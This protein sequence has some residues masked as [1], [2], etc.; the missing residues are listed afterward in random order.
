[1]DRYIEDIVQSEKNGLYLLE[2]PT[3]SGKTYNSLKVMSRV[4]LK[5]MTE[6]CSDECSTSKIVYIT[7]LVKNIKDVSDDLKKQLGNLYDQNVVWIKSNADNCLTLMNVKSSD[8]TPEIRNSEEFK[9]LMRILDKLQ[10]NKSFDKNYT[11]YLLEKEFP[12]TERRFRNFIK[13]YYRRKTEHIKENRNVAIMNLI[14]KENPWLFDMYPSAL[15]SEKKIILLSV[16]KLMTKANMLNGPDIP[17]L[18]NA[19]INENTTILLDEFDASKNNITSS[20][21]RE[22]LDCVIDYIKLCRQLVKYINEEDLSI[23]LKESF[24][25]DSQY[26]F[27]TL[28]EK[29]KIFES[30]YKISSSFKSMIE[31][32]HNV[33]LFNDGLYQTVLQNNDLKNKNYLSCKYNE[34]KFLNEVFLSGDEKESI[35]LY[36]MLRSIHNYL[37]YFHK[38]VERW[39]LNYEKNEN[40]ERLN[41][42]Q[43]A[44]KITL[45]DCV[46]TILNRF[47]LDEKQK[48]FLT[49]RISTIQTKK[50]KGFC[51]DLSFYHN[52][53][54]YF[55]LKDKDYENDETNIGMKKIDKTAEKVLLYLIQRAKVVGISA[56]AEVDSVISNYDF[57]YLKIYG[58]VFKTPEDVKKRIADEMEKIWNRYEQEKI[59]IHL[60]TMPGRKN[61]EES[62]LPQKDLYEY[63]NQPFL[64]QIGKEICKYYDEKNVQYDQS[65]HIQVLKVAYDLLSTEHFQSLL[66]IGSKIPREKDIHFDATLLKRNFD[67]MAREIGV[68]AH[69]FILCKEN[70]DQDIEKAKKIL[71]KGEKV[72]LVSSYATLAEGQNI[73]YTIP[74]KADVV[75]LSEERGVTEKDLDGI[76]LD[77][78]T[79]VTANLNDE[80]DDE[81]LLKYII[82]IEELYENGELSFHQKQYAVEKGIQAA[83]SSKKRFKNDIYDCKSIKNTKTAKVIQAVG[84]INRTFNKSRN[85]YIYISN[86]LLSEINKNE[87]RR[88]LMSPELKAIY[89]VLEDKKAEDNNQESNI[90]NV[91]STKAY[92]FIQQMLKTQWTT[93]TV[94]LWKDIRM[95]AAKN[96]TISKEFYEEHKEKCFYMYIP[97]DQ[98]RYYYKSFGDFKQVTVHMEKKQ[99]GDMEVSAEAAGLDILSKNE[100]IRESFE[101]DGYPMTFEKRD[102]ILNPIFFHNI[103]LGWLGEYVGK[104]LIEDFTKIT[105]KEIDDLDVFE[106]FDYQYKDLFFDFKNWKNTYQIDKSAMRKKINKKRESV[107]GRAV[108]TVNII[109]RGDYQPEETVDGK[110]I[111][112]KS[113]VNEDGS[114]NTKSLNIVK[115]KIYDYESSQCNME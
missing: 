6:L 59:K 57:N 63:G 41:K 5:K 94:S 86:D 48:S 26:N 58:N 97:C 35:S 77:D 96:P 11:E 61:I 37:N 9:Q 83:C 49:K 56:T 3:G 46:Q 98:V 24:P 2:V 21:I 43:L 101:R 54:E 40:Q 93:N 109:S 69:L 8:I 67:K 51:G 34:E 73:K 68:K 66:Y 92:L 47:K 33:Y 90:I 30:D 50:E 13:K 53:F 15:I 89:N 7:H 115:E 25:K 17:F 10:S 79:N 19:F 38:F 91:I 107:N 39:A 72:L 110:Q 102:Y 28:E 71:S 103:Y 75:C 88:R 18:S 27:K 31:N 36:Q 99:T 100:K 23:K 12:S 70:F 85:I 82:Q 1:M 74:E 65:R 20:I 95:F 106:V 64:K 81:N 55:E 45:E 113:L 32:N 62:Y 76:Y 78:I 52:G 16:N 4:C 42:N 29:G 105:L 108:F 104:M 60:V 111:E 114:L 84:R 44:N 87:L 112:I 22:A 80:L 14:K